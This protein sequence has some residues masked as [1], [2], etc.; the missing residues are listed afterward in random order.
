MV[1]KPIQAVPSR[2]ETS[3]VVVDMR[4]SLLDVAVAN[5]SKI[6]DGG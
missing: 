6:E 2:L 5:N 3:I 4:I 1:S